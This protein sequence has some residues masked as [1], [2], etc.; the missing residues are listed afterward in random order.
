M[1]EGMEGQPTKTNQPEDKTPQVQN[2]VDDEGIE[3]VPGPVT[4]GK[5]N[6]NVPKEHGR[7]TGSN[8]K[9]SMKLTTAA[10]QDVVYKI[11]K[12]ISFAHKEMR[13]CHNIKRLSKEKKELL[14]AKVW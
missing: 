1:P 8:K 4:V 7:P 6:K 12:L 10:V 9:D 11:E 5:P 13:S 14:D 3:P 2:V